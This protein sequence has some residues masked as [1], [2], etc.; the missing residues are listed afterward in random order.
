MANGALPGLSD[1]PPNAAVWCHA[2]GGGGRGH[3]GRQRG[4][5]VLAHKVAHGARD[6]L[7]AVRVGTRGDQAEVSS[8]AQLQD[9]RQRDLLYRVRTGERE[10]EGRWEERERRRR[11]K[12]E[13]R[14]G[15][16]GTRQSKWS[17][18][19]RRREKEEWRRAKRGKRKETG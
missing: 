12:V 19:E 6:D 16:T 2:A 17:E 10:K 7:K 13:K 3:V 1:L 9:L 11:G 15:V 8:R 18:K 14:P 4:V 5:G